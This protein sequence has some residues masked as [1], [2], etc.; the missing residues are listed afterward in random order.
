MRE[1]PLTQSKVAL[2]DDRLYERLSRLKWYAMDNKNTFYAVRKIRI[3][4]KRT[5]E[6]MHRAILNLSHGDGKITDHKNRN[7][8]DNRGDNLRIVPQSINMA[9]SKLN[10]KNTSGFRGVSWVERLKKWKAYIYNG[11]KQIYL[12][13]YPTLLSAALAYDSAA[14]N[15]WGVDAPLN[16]PV[17]R[18]PEFSVISRGI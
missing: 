13:L 4:E 12:G 2:V 5:I 6:M 17:E 8:L 11:Q 7:G 15:H 3:G 16:I 18:S 9:N 1:I 14:I 10:R